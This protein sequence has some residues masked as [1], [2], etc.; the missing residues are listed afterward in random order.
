MKTF[1]IRSGGSCYAVEGKQDENLMKA[2]ETYLSDRNKNN[3]R[4]YGSAGKDN[5]LLKS[6]LNNLQNC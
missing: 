6:V 4:R 5:V 1:K 3:I 2:A